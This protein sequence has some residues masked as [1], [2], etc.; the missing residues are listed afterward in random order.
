LALLQIGAPELIGTKD[1]DDLLDN[2]ESETEPAHDH[3]FTLL[4]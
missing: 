2:S 4:G 1:E 3:F